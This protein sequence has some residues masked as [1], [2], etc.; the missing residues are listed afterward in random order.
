MSIRTQ[1]LRVESAD[2]ADGAIRQAA[3]L[4]REGKLVAFPT[5]TVYGLGA[6]V[7]DEAAVRAVF[8][9]KGRPASVPLIVH[10]RGLDQ[11]QEYV[12][13]MPEAGMALAKAHWPG[14]LTLVMTRSRRVPDA[15]TAGGDSVGVRAPR[16][17]V[18]LSLI[19]ALGEGIAAPSAN[20]YDRLP[21]V[22]AEHVLGGLDGRID[23]VLDGGLCPGG[24]ESTV[25]DIR[26]EPAVVL[27]RGAV[28]PSRLGLELRAQPSR[29]PE[30]MQGAWLHVGEASGFGAWARTEG[31]S[32]GRLRLGSGTSSA[33]Q[34]VLRDEPE[35]YAAQMY[36]AL[37]ALWDARCPQ[38]WVDAPPRDGRWQPIWDRL[39]RL[40]S[41]L[42]RP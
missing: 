30:R 39:A 35:V 19:E 22:R 14:P 20:L 12:S 31:A 2:P 42:P 27:R 38:V 16:H 21:P 7:A 9:A 25:V 34:R 5:E 17:A 13:E 18:A 37:H 3:Q 33:Q 1:W 41:S 26:Q 29:L 6:R 4:L 40:A 36:D 11:A 10:V 8:R 28:E 23:A 15:V 32:V 24:L